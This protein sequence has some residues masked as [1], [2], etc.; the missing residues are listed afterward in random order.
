MSC[1][2]AS[3]E[4]QERTPI[5]LAETDRAGF[6]TDTPQMPR[7]FVARQDLAGNHHPLQPLE[8]EPCDIVIGSVPA[9]VSRC[10]AFGAFPP[11][12]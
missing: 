8:R 1:P 6:A 12:W 2:I 10:A 9:G 3:C 4:S 7:D 5:R 11:H